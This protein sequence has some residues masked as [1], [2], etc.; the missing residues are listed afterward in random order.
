G[1][2]GVSAASPGG[3]GAARRAGGGGERLRR[4]PLDGLD[5]LV[6][7]GR[8]V[9]GRGV[10]ADLA[11]RPR[12]LDF[13]LDVDGHQGGVQPVAW[14]YTSKLVSAGGVGNPP[15]IPCCIRGTSTWSRN[16][17]QLSCESW[18]ATIV[19]PS[20]EGPAAWKI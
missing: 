4:L 15:S 10:R 11:P 13:R 1:P 12:D 17:S 14:L 18:T 9:R 7:G 3:A 19:Q 5:V 20:A 2:V 8:V 6:P 16:R